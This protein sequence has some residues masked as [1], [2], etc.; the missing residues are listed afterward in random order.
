MAANSALE[1]VLKRDRAAVL[2]G[3]AGVAALAWIYLIFLPAGMPDMPA[4]MAAARMMPWGVADFALMFLM[5]AV[6][7]V[8]MMVPSAAPMILI[9]AAVCRRNREEGRP[10]V[11]TGVFLVGYL[12]AW[13]GFSLLATLAQWALHSA[14]L[15]SPMMTGTSPLLGGALFLAAG[16]FQWT[17]LKHACLRNCRSPFAFIARSWR[18]GAGGALRMG[19]EHGAYC[20][21]CCWFLMGLLFAGGVMNLLWVAG[22]TLFVLAEKAAPRGEW[23]ARLSG[24]AMAAA[25]GFILFSA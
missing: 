3:I 12:A 16:I 7:M 14:A 5:W 19:L 23:V 21:G 25:G 22:I 1:I 2:A 17:P 13:T 6:M 24:A 18:P 11:P 9:Y 15:L 20:V 10:F 8:G 4:A